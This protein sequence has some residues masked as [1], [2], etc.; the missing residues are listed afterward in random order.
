MNKLDKNTAKDLLNKIDAIK[1]DL[2]AAKGNPAI[3][4]ANQLAAIVSIISPY[5]NELSNDIQVQVNSF[6]IA[7]RAAQKGDET[8]S[9]PIYKLI[10]PTKKVIVDYLENLTI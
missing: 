2:V 4:K 5:Q 1:L 9:K 10:D 3:A 7:Y 6:V 8:F